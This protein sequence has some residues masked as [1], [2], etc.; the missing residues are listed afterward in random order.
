MGEV[1]AV[2]RVPTIIIIIIVFISISWWWK[3]EKK[4]V[5]GQLDGTPATVRQQAGIAKNNVF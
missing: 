5:T 2:V 3:L 1:I 4:A